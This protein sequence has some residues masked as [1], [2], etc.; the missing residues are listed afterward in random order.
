MWLLNTHRAELQFF[1]TPHS[2]PK[3]YAILSH[4][5]DGEE[6]SF[7]DIQALRAQCASTGANPRDLTSPKVRNF[8]LLAEQHGYDWVWID[9]CCIDK[10]SSAELSEAINSMFRWYSLAETCYAYL[11][12]VSRATFSHDAA[13]ARTFCQ[14]RWHTRG[15]TLQELI[16]PDIVV[17]LS[18]EWKVLGTRVGLA[19]LLEKITNIPVEVLRLETELSSVS[20][21]ARMS[22]A[23]KRKTTRPEDEAYC[24]MGIF[25]INMPTLYGEGRQAFQRLQEEIMRRS[26]DTSL[27]AWGA[28]TERLP[29]LLWNLQ[30][31]LS[32][33]HGHIEGSCLFASAPSAFRSSGDVVFTPTLP[34]CSSRLLPRFLILKFYCRAPIRD[35]A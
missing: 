3:G 26:T 11:A 22:W 13:G 9:T 7:H 32:M 35:G 1:P 12:D 14:S 16:A 24:L 5:W 10:S 23:A 27:F 25:R 8:C 21:A 2:V 17:F 19:D 29:D 33:V 6:E 20:I 34:V 28:P 30:D 15:W 18:S 4:V 31:D